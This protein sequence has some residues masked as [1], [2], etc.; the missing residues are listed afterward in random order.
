[1]MTNPL[2]LVGDGRGAGANAIIL[3]GPVSM[4]EAASLDA[5]LVARSK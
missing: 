5:H 2:R 3:V 1:M 4:S